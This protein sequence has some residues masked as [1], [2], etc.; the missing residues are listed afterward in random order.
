ML[1]KANDTVNPSQAENC[2]PLHIFIVY[3]YVCINFVI[4][5]HVYVHM[6]TQLE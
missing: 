3:I 5:I 1:Y 6:H 4:T 2:Q